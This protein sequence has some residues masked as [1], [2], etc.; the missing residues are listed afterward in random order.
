MFGRKA[1]Q[2]GVA[3][4]LPLLVSLAACS[5]SEEEA[6][7]RSVVLIT[8]GT[9]RADAL[10]SVGAP[11][12]TTPNLDALAAESLRYRWARTVAPLT[13]PAHTSMFTGYY[14]LRHG[15]R[16]NGP[17][18]VP[19]VLETLAERARWAGFETAGFVGSS[20][21]S[22]HLGIAQGFRAWRQPE[23]TDERVARQY[24]TTAA[25]D[26]VN[27]V[28]RWLGRR[29]PAQPFFLWVHFADAHAPYTPLPELYLQPD[30]YL[31]EVSGVD[32]A[33]GRLLDELGKSRA[34][35]APLIAVIGD[36]GEGRGDHD[37]SLH[38]FYCF[39]TTLRVPFLLHYPDGWRAGEVSDEI[40]T[41][42]DVFPTLLEF[43]GMQVPQNTD[44]VS[45][46]RRTVPADRGVYFESYLGWQRF[47]WS[48]LAGWADGEGKYVHG[49]TPEFYR[50]ALDPHEGTDLIDE[51]FERARYVEAIRRLDQ[52]PKFLG[53]GALA[54]AAP[55][56]LADSDR[57]APRAQAQEHADFLLGLEL[58]GM[59]DHAGA[60]PVLERVV[61][62]NDQNAAALDALARALIGIREHARAL[63]VLQQRLDLL[64]EK[65]GTH[66]DLVTC[67]EALGQ[68]QPAHE[69]SVRSLELLVQTYERQHRRDEASR[70]RGLLKQ[71]RRQEVPADADS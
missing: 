34:I 12:G 9:T 40:V 47:G 54:L 20:A 59:G 56:P 13:L 69:H 4:G 70:M 23:G 29:N 46:L 39:D 68:A 31:A 41:V 58:I 51:E 27:G 61:A 7:A 36:H 65:V 48:P 16:C 44:G 52:E 3:L 53:E 43:M 15:V 19:E 67:Y 38:G 63:L 24:A 50:P 32:L 33:F 45:L 22:E 25:D 14:P 64:P 30:P 10:S 18:V 8:L 2:L 49:S 11:P 35:D 57:P 66:R 5:G 17:T 62:E 6:L 26:V 28:I 1:K 21:L 55:A 60:V 42:A 37:E 71:V